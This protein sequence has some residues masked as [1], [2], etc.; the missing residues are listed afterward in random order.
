MSCWHDHSTILKDLRILLFG[1]LYSAICVTC[2]CVRCIGQRRRREYT[3][4][5]GQMDLPSEKCGGE[6]SSGAA[7][8]DLCHPAHILHDLTPLLSACDILQPLSKTVLL[9]PSGSIVAILEQERKNMIE[10]AD[11]QEEPSIE[12]VSFP[13]SSSSSSEDA[14]SVHMNLP[15]AVESPPTQGDD[16]SQATSPPTER[17]AE[18]DEQV[19]SCS[20]AFSATGSVQK[21]S[22]RLEFLHAVDEE[23][24]RTWRRWVVEYS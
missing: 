13:S 11:E 10:I 16:S 4:S 1:T 2:I 21:R 24:V 8:E 18:K 3:S 19:C 17:A 15:S 6:E 12:P 5:K 14:P 23:G 7:G 20:P 9:P 22:Q